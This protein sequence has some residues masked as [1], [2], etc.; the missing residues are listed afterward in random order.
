MSQ[1]L[2]NSHALPSSHKMKS[3][4]ISPEPSMK[5]TKIGNYIISSTLGEGTFSKVKLGVH[6]P[7]Q[8]KVAIKILDKSKIKDESDIERISREI[9]ILKAI[10]HPNIVQLY[11]TITTD[12]ASGH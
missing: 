12:N 9:H 5:C 11:E 3:S 8:Q 4:C 1:E 10:R 6:L 7:T 2:V